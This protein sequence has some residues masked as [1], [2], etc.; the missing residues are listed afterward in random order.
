MIV[1]FILV[2]SINQQINTRIL[3]IVLL[4]KNPINTDHSDL[5]EKNESNLK[6]S[7]FKVNDIVGITKYKNIFSKGNF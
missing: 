1:N 2:I 3:N 5:T 7:K 6:A 4:K